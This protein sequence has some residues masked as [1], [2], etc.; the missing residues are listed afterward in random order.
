MTKEMSGSET[1]MGMVEVITVWQ[2]RTATSAA[3][4]TDELVSDRRSFLVALLD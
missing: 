2:P 4:E 1:S 3:G